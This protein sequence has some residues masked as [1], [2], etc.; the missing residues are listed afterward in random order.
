MTEAELLIKARK[1]DRQALSDLL[2][3]HQ[4]KVYSA[5]LAV[6][7]NR[8][9][10]LDLTQET[11]VMVCKK[12]NQCH[13]SFLPWCLTILKNLFIS[14]IRRKKGQ[15]ISISIDDLSYIAEEGPSIEEKVE[16]S[17]T[18]ETLRSELSKLPEEYRWVLVLRYIEELSIK[19]IAT[20]LELKEGTVKSQL[21]RGKSLLRK[22]L[23]SINKGGNTH[24]L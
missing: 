18:Q 12:I 19:E 20:T 5:A 8:E 15:E 9:L 2:Y 4:S 21:F 6:T 22:K 1:G 3:K 23:T 24:G 13:T 7:G 10:A 11:F 17:F 14:Q 16:L